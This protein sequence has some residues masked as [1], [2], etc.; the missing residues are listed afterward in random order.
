M[1]YSVSGRITTQIEGALWN[2]GRVEICGNDTD[3]PELQTQR[4]EPH[5]KFLER[6]GGRIACYCLVLQPVFVP[7][8]VPKI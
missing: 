1:A 6:G 5:I 2:G 8:V 3:I 7:F 4:N